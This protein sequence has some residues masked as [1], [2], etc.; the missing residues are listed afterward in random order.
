MGGKLFLGEGPFLSVLSSAHGYILGI[1][2][3]VSNTAAK[4]VDRTSKSQAGSPLGCWCMTSGESVSL[5][6]NW[7]VE[8][9]EGKSRCGCFSPVSSLTEQENDRME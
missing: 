8:K 4:E 7:V 3:P 5:L 6:A 9:G 1:K 2:Y